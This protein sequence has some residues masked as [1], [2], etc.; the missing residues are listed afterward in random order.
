[1]LL[2]MLG[3][4]SWIPGIPIGIPG[5]QESHPNMTIGTPM[6]FLPPPRGGGGGPDNSWVSPKGPK[7]PKKS[8]IAKN[9][10][11]NSTN[12]EHYAPQ[13]TNKLARTWRSMHYWS[14]KLPFET[15]L[16]ESFLLS[17][18]QKLLEP[19]GCNPARRGCEAL[20]KNDPK[21]IMKLIVWN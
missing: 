9:E 14:S 16:Y 19:P 17:V 12:N 7:D 11:R 5:F 3:W 13:V 21:S 15:E 10:Y 20:L 18:G 8:E 1:M 6:N 4:D 2:V